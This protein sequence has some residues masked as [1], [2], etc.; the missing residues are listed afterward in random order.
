[1]V[2][3]QQA[4][5]SAVADRAGEVVV[6]SAP[7]ELEQPDGVAEKGEDADHGEQRQQAD[8][9][10]AG[11]RDQGEGDGRGD[12]QGSQDKHQER[13]ACAFAAVEGG[14]GDLIA[15]AG[16]GLSLAPRS[17]RCGANH[18]R[19]RACGVRRAFAMAP[20]PPEWPNGRRAQE[21]AASPRPA[22]TI[23]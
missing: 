18:L 19:A 5:R 4:F 12:E 17:R 3:D 11:L 6:H 10:A 1:M 15:H 16:F 8:D 2:G 20:A 9:V 14:G 22:L 7:G 21:N 13:R 23:R